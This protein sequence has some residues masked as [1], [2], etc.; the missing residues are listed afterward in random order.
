M[1]KKLK[2]VFILTAFALLGIIISQ[3]YWTINAYHVNKE[4]FEV[5]INTAMQKAMDD[6]KK[7]YFDSIRRVLVRRFSPPETTI[8]IDTLADDASQSRKLN[9]H[10]SNAATSFDLPISADTWDLYQKKIGLQGNNAA[11]LIEISF[12]QAG[13]TNML[14]TIPGMYDAMKAIKADKTHK[15]VYYDK[16]VNANI[17]PNSI[18]V[19]PPNFRA[20]DSVKLYRYFNQE[21]EKIRIRS[22]VSLVISTQSTPPSKL[23][24]H[25]SETAE[26][27]YKYHGLKALNFVGPEFFIRAVF[28]SPQMA[29][30]KSMLFILLLSGFLIVFII[31]SFS[32]IVRTFIKQKKLAELKDDFINN[33]TH[34]LKTPIATIAVAIEGLQKFN[35]L[36][37]IEKTQR[38]L[39]TSRNELSRLDNLVTKVLN[40]AVFENKE[41]ALVK[42]PVNVNNLVNDVIESEKLKTAKTVEII[43]VNKDDIRVL[44]ADKTH[45]RNVLVNLVDNAIKYSDDPV[46]VVISCNKNSGNAVFSVKDNGIGIPAAHLAQVFDKFHRVPYGNVHTVKGT[47]LGLSYVKYIVEAHGGNV[48]V[49]SATNA[50]SE[51]IVSI[52]LSNG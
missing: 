26:Y 13:L 18:Y 52:P 8:R 27:S 46:N 41:I 34:E 38:Y 44:H 50:G 35:A 25:Y 48:T 6:C 28:P 21:L 33:M 22:K 14:I 5:N 30:L 7:D 23:N 29:V 16:A 31:F 47:G 15:G 20:A 17:I 9:I 39:Q 45:F 11:V 2:I 1:K 12:Y 32:Y 36:G 4:K 42:E 43:F 3:T 19:Y 10:I 40:I 37:D 51:F 24:L 49:K